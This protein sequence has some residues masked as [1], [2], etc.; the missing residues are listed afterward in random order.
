M[1]LDFDQDIADYFLT[2]HIK[3]PHKSEE[4][5]II[6]TSEIRDVQSNL[7]S[8]ETLQNLLYFICTKTQRYFFRFSFR[9]TY[10]IFSP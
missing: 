10:I 7:L 2:I 6:H 4:V 3:K 5:I 9:A 8:K 1:E